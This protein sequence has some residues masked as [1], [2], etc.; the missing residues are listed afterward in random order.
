VPVFV[1]R[2]AHGGKSGRQPGVGNGT[3]VARLLK[4]SLCRP[5][6]RRHPFALS[7]AA[8]NRLDFGKSRALI[9]ASQP[10][11]P[12]RVNPKIFLENP[13]LNAPEFHLNSGYATQ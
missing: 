5:R 7:R 9:G 1:K 12:P 3:T 6:A 2:S 13:Q 4:A 10:P 8:G 11:A